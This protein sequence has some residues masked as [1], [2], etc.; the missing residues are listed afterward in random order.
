[1]SDNAATKPKRRRRIATPPP[2]DAAE[3][4]E[5]HYDRVVS[6]TFKDINAGEGIFGTVECFSLLDT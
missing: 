5:D 6:N 1:M 3:P 4:T 2:D